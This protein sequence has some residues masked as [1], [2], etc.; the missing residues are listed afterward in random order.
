MKHNQNTAI[1]TDL[2]LVGGGHSHLFV[3]KH[4]AMNPID[5][6][7]LTLVTRD[8]KTPYSGMLPGYIAGHYRF[9]QA[10]IDLQPLARYAGARLIHG[11]VSSIDPERQIL[12]IPDRP[13]IKYDLLSINI[14]SRPARGC[15]VANLD[16]QFAIK[17]I[18]QF[19]QSWARFEKQLSEHDHARE[20]TV[21]GGGAGGVEL[22]LALEFRL[23]KAGLR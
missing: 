14:G 21:V 11:E 16:Q 3:L 12:S 2:V 5:G 4:L 15:S 23:R 18:D 6:L 13:D 8:L 9:E 1:S 20:L 22:V 17:P 7:R 19:L 10:H